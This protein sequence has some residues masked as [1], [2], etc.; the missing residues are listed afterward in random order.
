MRKNEIGTNL[1]EV[2]NG[3]LDKTIFLIEIEPIVKEFTKKFSKIFIELEQDDIYQKIYLYF[4]EK[5]EN[6]REI[7]NEEFLLWKI[8]TDI[9]RILRKEY[10]FKKVEL[11]ENLIIVNPF[12][13]GGFID[14][15]LTKETIFNIINNLTFLTKI[16]KKV[17]L[18]RFGFYGEIFTLAEIGQQ[19]HVTS[20]RIRQIEQNALKKIRENVYNLKDYLEIY[21]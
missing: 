3:T 7:V 19:Y 6:K 14:K 5:I 4:L 18:L 13:D 15:H 8:D 9:R 17:L 21:N 11:S 1:N 10:S 20:N 2:I 16:E 12:K